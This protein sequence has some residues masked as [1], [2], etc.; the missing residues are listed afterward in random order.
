[1]PKY[2]VSIKEVHSVDVEVDTGDIVHPTVSQLA[3]A[4]AKVHKSSDCLDVEYSHT[5]PPETWTFENSETKE[6][7]DDK[8][9]F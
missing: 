9:S 1:M 8:E 6:R 3:E 5:L 4:A 7:L 2:I